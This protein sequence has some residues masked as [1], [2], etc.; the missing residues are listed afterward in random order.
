MAR[1]RRSIDL[2]EHLRPRFWYFVFVACNVSSVAPVHFSI[3]AT[4]TRLGYQREFGMDQWG[5]LP[6]QLVFALAFFMLAAGT[7]VLATKRAAGPSVY[8]TRPLLFVLIVSII[9]SGASSLAIALHCVAFARDGWGMPWLEVLGVVCAT[10]SKCLLVFNSF[11]L[12]TGWA[13]LSSADKVVQ[14]T[15]VLGGLAT[16]AFISFACELHSAL[17]HDT[18]TALY[19]Y[20][21]DAGT[22]L[23]VMH[24][25][26]FV[27]YLISMRK[28]YAREESADVRLFYVRITSVYCVY[29]VTLP[30]V[31]IVACLI[32]P[33]WR[34][35]T[36]TCVELALRLATLVALVHSLWP[37]SL[38][39]VLRSRLDNAGF[40][41]AGQREEGDQLAE[42]LQTEVCE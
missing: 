37:S 18:S 38:D 36:V 40:A 30:A 4:N 25:A 13:L 31:V 29:F 20:D 34:F 14:R 28:T 42:E 8:R 12:A 2:F 35:K 1:F 15:L 17:V 5:S 22:T 23:L 41:A 10:A 7:H 6:L 19:L 16:V 21:S 24:V 27:T 32:S 33:E 39:A 11:L 9:L 3:H 26:F